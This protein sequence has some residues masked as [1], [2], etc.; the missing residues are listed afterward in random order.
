MS[1]P[2]GKNSPA[3]LNAFLKLYLEDQ[4]REQVRPLAEYQERFPGYEDQIAECY[5]SLQH[6][7]KTAASRATT[8]DMPPSGSDGGAGTIAVSP[9]GSEAPLPEEGATIASPAP[10]SDTE[11]PDD[12]PEAE[13][14]EGDTASQQPLRIGPYRL[15]KPLGEGGMG[16]VY[17]AAQTEPI[18]R[19]VA[20]KLVRSGMTSEEFLIRFE[21]ERQAIALMN[22]INIAKVF[23]AGATP[24]GNPYFAMEYAPGQPLNSYCEREELGL[25]QRLDLFLQVCSGVRH[26][27][28]KGIIHRDLKPSNILVGKEE[29][30]PVV[31]IIDFGV[32][33]SMDQR[34]T[35]KPLE[36]EAG[37]M[38]GTPEYMSPEQAEMGPAGIDTRT[39]VYALGVILYELLC[40]LLP[41]DSE[42]LRSGGFTEMK[43]LIC[44]ADPPKPSRRLGEFSEKD[45]ICEA[46]GVS[47]AELER[48]LRGDLDWI[49]MKAIDKDRMQRYQSA[50][51]LAD[52]IERY[53]V[54]DPVLAGPPTLAYK[55]KKF[56]RKHRVGI[57]SAVSLLVISTVIAVLTWQAGIRKTRQQRIER[58][59][60]K[61]QAAENHRANYLALSKKLQRDAVAWEIQNSR[62]QGWLPAWH[63]STIDLFENREDLDDTHSQLD[64]EFAAALRQLFEAGQEAPEDEAPL[65]DKIKKTTQEVYTNRGRQGLRQRDKLIPATSFIGEPTKNQALPITVRSAPPGAKIYLYRFVE[66]EFRLLPLPF[67]P[68]ADEAIDDEGLL[69]RAVLEFEAVHNPG[70]YA[71]QFEDGANRFEPGDRFLAIGTKPIRSRKDLAHALEQIAPAEKITVR[72]LR[73]SQTHSISWRPFPATEPGAPEDLL[74]HVARKMKKAKLLNI[75]HQ[76]GFTFAGSPLI[77]SPRNL[78]GATPISNEKSLRLQKG[79]YLLVLHIEGRPPVRVPIIIP[80]SMAAIA[81]HIPERVPEGFLYIP[82]GRFFAGGDDQSQARQNLEPFWYS[83]PEYFMSR[84]E[85]S[86]GEYL[87]FI[88]DPEVRARIDQNGNGQALADWSVLKKKG[89]VGSQARISLIPQYNGQLLFGRRTSGTWGRRKLNYKGQ[90]T[91][92]PPA[93]PL[94]GISMLAALEYAHWY[95]EKRDDGFSYRLPTDLE[96]EKA[97]RGVDKRTQVWGENPVGSF[98]RSKN[99][100]WQDFLFPGSTGVFPNDESVYGI[101]DMAGSVLEPTSGRT[102]GGYISFRG[103]WYGTSDDYLFHI[104]T[105]FGRPASKA[106]HDAGIRLVAM[107]SRK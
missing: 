1:D 93:G 95:T 80:G 106:Q 56:T 81:V 59:A 10:G 64:N 5:E 100:R 68:K 36:T 34:L 103:G 48:R 45:G 87:Q 49:I 62:H 73:G 51:D 20:L 37:Q 86:F 22:H 47:P 8:L 41:F 24:D 23:D 98:C 85:V 60:R 35:D 83:Q 17:L 2:G 11:Q 91:S 21:A 29:E 44:E 69:E 25:R 13:A 42:T 88:N 33:R 61:L 107:P 75:Y 9:P 40:G 14:T 101:R 71:S 46:F 52:D 90:V 92:A 27:H 15:I 26:A 57:L 70:L 7:G 65:L 84:L 16:I 105:R 67:H 3:I 77:R 79:S 99:S 82:A 32:A 6:S 76:L 38:V 50:N 12:S 28:Q 55:L 104:S 31:K 43:R 39:D 30:K 58:S 74:E 78:L 66:H 97:A 54:H 94:C 18:K 53:L 4:E 63:P 19:Q 96:W 102:I 72:V 89:L